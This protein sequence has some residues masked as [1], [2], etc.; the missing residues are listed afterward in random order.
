MGF[1]G[2]FEWVGSVSLSLLATAGPMGMALLAGGVQSPLSEK[3]RTSAQRRWGKEGRK[4]EPKPYHPGGE[5]MESSLPGTQP[6]MTR[7]FFL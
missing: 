1:V 7:L 3:S 4:Q 6:P 2:E 5:M